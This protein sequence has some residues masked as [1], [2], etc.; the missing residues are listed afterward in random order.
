MVVLRRLCEAETAPRV[1]PG[2]AAVGAALAAM[3]IPVAGPA[4]PAAAP[5]APA[6]LAAL[7]DPLLVPLS[8]F[9]RCLLFVLTAERSALHLDAM[10]VARPANVPPSPPFVGQ[11]PALA[12]PLDQVLDRLDAAIARGRG[13][14][15]VQAL[16]RSIVAHIVVKAMSRS[17]NEGDPEARLEGGFVRVANVTGPSWNGAVDDA[18]DSDDVLLDDDDVV[19]QWKNDVDAVVA[20]VGAPLKG[21]FLSPRCRRRR[22]SRPCCAPGAAAG[23]GGSGGGRPLPP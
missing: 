20:S 19:A 3:P 22:F 11:I 9:V 23:E 7:D 13:N 6:A 14:P 1:A 4:A 21:L 10:A 8:R 2:V 5:A 15:A 16:L 12:L 18:N 17:L